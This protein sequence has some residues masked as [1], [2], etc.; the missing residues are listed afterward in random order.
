MAMVAHMQQLDLR[1]KRNNPRIDGLQISFQQWDKTNK[2]KTP[3]PKVKVNKLQHEKTGT[4]PWD[5]FKKTPMDEATKKKYAEELKAMG[6]WVDPEA[7]GKM[8]GAQ[9][10]EHSNKVRAMRRA[11]K[12]GSNPTT[13]QAMHHMQLP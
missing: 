10:K 4:D 2:P 3:W 7:F 11:K 8:L 12:E 13:A 1:D 6:M 5:K 9:H